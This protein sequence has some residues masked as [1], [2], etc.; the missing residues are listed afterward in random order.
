[1]VIFNKI[2]NKITKNSLQKKFR[3]D[4]QTKYI[5]TCIYDI[6]TVHMIYTYVYIIYTRKNSKLLMIK[7]Q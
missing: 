5:H 4:S 1:M 3:I 2:A 6:H 7:G